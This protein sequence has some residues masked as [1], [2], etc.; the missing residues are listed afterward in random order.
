MKISIYRSLM[1]ST[2]AACVAVL[3]GCAVGPVPY[4]IRA[5]ADPVI[6]R[7][8][9]G[10]PLSV[11][12]RLYQLKQRK[13][14]NQ[15]TFDLISSN[16]SD[17]ELFG[18]SLLKRSEIVLVPGTSH[19]STETLLADTKYLG[20]VAF[21]RRPDAHYWRF[22]IDADQ[23]RKRGLSFRVRDCYLT[24]KD[25]TPVPI[26]GQPLDA[27]PVCIETRAD[28][29]PN[30]PAKNAANAPPPA[31]LA[32]KSSA[33]SKSKNQRLRI[34]TRHGPVEV[35]ATTTPSTDATSDSG[36]SVPPPIEIRIG[37]NLNWGAQ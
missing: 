17:A 18:D 22:L 31:A 7:D 19:G 6:N 36:A 2:V 37:P 35:N 16:R 9:T 24:L 23:I 26:P 5:D 13:E 21:F 27:K 1:L 28:A 10:N 4:N 20:V 34:P 33:S 12:I 3:S 29:P 11:V 25:N 32:D 14:F 15:L 30:F 8:T